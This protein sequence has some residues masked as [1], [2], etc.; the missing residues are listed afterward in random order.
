MPALVRLYIRHSLIGFAIAIAFVAMLLGADVAGLRGLILG[1]PV[2]WL[3]L[4]MLV[5]FN[6]FLF[7][8]VQ[9]GIAVMR[10]GD[11]PHDD[12]GGKRLREGGERLRTSL[13]PPPEAIPAA[14]Q[15]RR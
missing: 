2:G 11:I 13:T 7:A 1:S 12:P 9:F 4:V 15:S 10:M 3:A 5:L 8:G 6:G 14:E